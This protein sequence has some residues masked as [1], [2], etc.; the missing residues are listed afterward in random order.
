[1]NE[2]EALQLWEKG[3]YKMYYSELSDLLKEYIK[4]TMAMPTDQLTSSELVKIFK[5]EKNLRGL[6]K[7]LRDILLTADI[8]KFAKG[9]PHEDYK[10]K[11]ISDTEIIINS[12]EQIKL[13]EKDH[14]Q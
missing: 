7:P 2:L 12:I 6:H 4:D 3:E 13:S 14:D 1:M 11:A 5:K 8:T 10:I 9:V